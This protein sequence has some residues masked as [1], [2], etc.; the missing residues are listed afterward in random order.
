MGIVFYTRDPTR[1]AFSMAH[2]TWA[3]PEMGK[4]QR[5][6]SPRLKHQ[7]VEI[8]I[9][10]HQDICTSLQTSKVLPSKRALGCQQW[11]FDKLGSQIQKGQMNVCWIQILMALEFESKN[12]LSWHGKTLHSKFQ[13]CHPSDWTHC[14][15]YTCCIFIRLPTSAHC[16]LSCGMALRVMPSWTF[17]IFVWNSG[18]L[19]DVSNRSDWNPQ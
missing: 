5:E 12:N 2:L 4:Q 3:M 11:S 15:A 14:C 10:C 8:V 7:S 18:G 6:A 1:P 13:I 16:C 17:H 19:Q 9:Y